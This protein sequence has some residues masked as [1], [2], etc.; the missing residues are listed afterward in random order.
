MAKLV[1]G[2]FYGA[3]T[4][5]ERGQVVIPAEI[6][7]ALKISAGDKMIVFAKPD[8]VGF[9][10]A[11]EFSRFLDQATATMASLKK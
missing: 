9:M 10:P 3:V 5:G 2:K 8:M 7:K 1:K 4:V 6:R 11:Q